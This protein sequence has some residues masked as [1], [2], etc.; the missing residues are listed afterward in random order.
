MGPS[1]PHRWIRLRWSESSRRGDSR[2]RGSALHT[3][4]SSHR[5]PKFGVA[6]GDR[7]GESGPDWSGER[8]MAPG[9]RGASGPGADPGTG[10]GSGASGR[11][12]RRATRGGA[13]SSPLRRLR[14][15]RRAGSAPTPPTRPRGADAARDAGRDTPISVRTPS[16]PGARRC[17]ETSVREAKGVSGS[18]TI[19]RVTIELRGDARSRRSS[20]ARGSRRTK[21]TPPRLPSARGGADLSPTGG[22]GLRN[23]S[24]SMCYISTCY[25]SSLSRAVSRSVGVTSR[26]S[27]PFGSEGSGIRAGDRPPDP[28]VALEAARS[29][30]GVLMD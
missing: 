9:P 29:D 30:E 21:P 11:L 17:C 6:R 2:E 19:L 7:D 23:R 4:V 3:G 18:V 20:G 16:L 28:R 1:F 12:D 27:V 25:V 8:L 26:R 22:L 14:R 24:C 13:D 5:E 15:R 10:S